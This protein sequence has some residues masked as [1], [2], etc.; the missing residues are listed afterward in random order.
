MT[1]GH[2]AEDCR[3]RRGPAM[4]EPERMTSVERLKKA[5]HLARV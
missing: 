3:C 1:L 4:I 2:P 5:R